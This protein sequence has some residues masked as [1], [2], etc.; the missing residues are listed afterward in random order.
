M[1]CKSHI[2]NKTFLY[3]EKNKWS[4]DF[5][6]R[7]KGHEPET[8]KKLMLVFIGVLIVCIAIIVLFATNLL[9]KWL[10]VAC[11]SPDPTRDPT[12][13]PDPCP[14]SPIVLPEFDGEFGN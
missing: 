10:S 14:T 7:V 1:S 11:Q 3:D 2:N 5:S 13:T 6:Q 4:T 8:N 9:C 12:R